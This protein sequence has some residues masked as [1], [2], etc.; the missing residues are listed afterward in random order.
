MQVSEIIWII[1][2]SVGLPSMAAETLS[3][4]KGFDASFPLRHRLSELLGRDLPLLILTDS[5]LDV[6]FTEKRTREACLTIDNY[7]VRQSIARKDLDNIGLIRSEDNL[8]DELSNMDGNGALFR[9]MQF[10]YVDDQVQDF[11][12]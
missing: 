3:F 12:L 8:A 9:A 4:V 6:L 10:G 1:R 2:P 7:A 5:L 11:L